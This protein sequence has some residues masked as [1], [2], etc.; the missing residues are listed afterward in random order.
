MERELDRLEQLDIIEKARGP[1][2]WVS[3]IVVVPKKTGGVRIC[4]D[5]REANKAVQREKHPIPTIDELVTD[6]NGATV[7]ST[8]DMSSAY[9]QLPLAENSHYITTFTT[10][11]GLYRY[12]RLMFGINAAAEIFQNAIWELIKDLPGCR[13]ISDDILVYG[14][15]T[16]EHHENLARILQRLEEKGARLNWDKCHFSQTEVEFYGHIFSKDGIRA[17]PKKIKAIANIPAP[18]NVTELRSLL[19]MAQYVVKFRNT[20]KA[21]SH[22]NR[23]S[24]VML[25]HLLK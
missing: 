22:V 21:V 15:D 1:T 25:T 19:G 11:V 6:L 7:F 8:L 24:K 12:K 2:P 9:H 18:T 14:Q 23:P 10:H 17:D 16:Q 3:P 20:L 5:M 13:N 4:V